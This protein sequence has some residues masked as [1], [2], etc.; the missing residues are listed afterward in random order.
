MKIKFLF[1]LVLFFNINCAEHNVFYEPGEEICIKNSSNINVIIELNNCWQDIRLKPNEE[2]TIE[3]CLLKINKKIDWICVYA[4]Q[5]TG[6]ST[7]DG[8]LK[9]GKT[10]EIKYEANHYKCYYN[11][12]D[13]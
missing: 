11:I 13:R 3:L 6:Y 9:I 5:P 12:I 4:A 2:I 8:P 10:Y 1:F 7:F